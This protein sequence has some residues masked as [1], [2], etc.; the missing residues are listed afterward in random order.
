MTQSIKETIA[1]HY[2]EG[3]ASPLPGDYWVIDSRHPFRAQGPF[4]LPKAKEFAE[5]LGMFLIRNGENPENPFQVYDIEGKKVDLSKAIISLRVI[6]FSSESETISNLGATWIP[7]LG[8][9]IVDVVSNRLG[10]SL[11]LTP[12]EQKVFFD[13]KQIKKENR[14]LRKLD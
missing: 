11:N 8:K 13:G 12:E 5:A 1:R 14:I 10:V 4:T 3:T 7:H 6:M 9:L 2:S